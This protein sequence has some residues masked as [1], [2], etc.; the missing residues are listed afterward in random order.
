MFNPI[1]TA[2]NLVFLLLLLM[3][4]S[5]THLKAFEMGFKTGSEPS[6]QN[7]AIKFVLSTLG[8]K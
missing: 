3:G 5:Y 2:L 7:T 4:F 6:M 8:G 1:R